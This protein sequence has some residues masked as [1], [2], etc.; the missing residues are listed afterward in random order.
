MANVNGIYVPFIVDV[1]GGMKYAEEQVEEQ[2]KRLMDKMS[3]HA[4]SLRF[5]IDRDGKGKAVLKSVNQLLTDSTLSAENLDNALKSI[6]KRITDARA[7][8]GFDM[9][10]GLTET[11]K[12]LLQVFTVVSAKYEGVGLLLDKLMSDTKAWAKENVESAK[13]V[14][15]YWDKIDAVIATTGNSF[16]EA[17]ARMKAAMTKL[18]V[19][20]A[21]L[22]DGS[23]NVE[24]TNLVSIVKQA[25][26]AIFEYQ[27]QLG[28]VTNTSRENIQVLQEQEQTMSV[29]NRQM[30]EWRKILENSEVG[31]E[32]FT[33][34][35]RQMGVLADAIAKANYQFQ[36]LSSNKDSI[37][38]VSARMAELNRQW[39]EA[40]ASKKFGANG[41]MTA[42]AKQMVEQYKDLS[43]FSEKYGQ[44]LEHFIAKR[45]E[46]MEHAD[47]LRNIGASM[48]ALNQSLAAWTQELNNAPI[49][50]PEWVNA[51]QHVQSL[52]NKIR[53][54]NDKL[55]E[56]ALQNG[57]IEQ[58]NARLQSLTNQWNSLGNRFSA[59]GQMTMEAKKIYNEYVKV[60][61]QLQKEGR[62][63]SD[64]LSKQEALTQKLLEDGRIRKR[65]Q[66]ILTSEANTIDRIRQKIQLLTDQLGKV[67]IGSDRFKAISR[68]IAGLNEQ[69]EKAQG[70]TAAVNAELGRSNSLLG[71]LV[72]KTLYLFSLRT[73]STF[74]RN[75]RQVT[76]EFEMQRVALAGIIQDT[77]KAESLFKQIKAAAIK[78]PFEIKDLVRFTKQLSAYRI[79]TDQLFDVTMKL[80]DVSAGLGVDMNRLVLAY[81]QVRAASVLRGQE[82]RQFTEAGIP[83]VE[84]LAKKFTE[85]NGRMVSTAE[86]FELISKRAV[87]FSMIKEIFDDMTESGGMFYKMQEKQSETLLGQWQ[88]LKDAASIMYDEMGNMSNVHNIMEQMMATTMRLMQNW[89]LLVGV[90]KAVGIEFLTIKAVSQFLP[91]LARNTML[92]K[93]AQD[94]FNRSLAAE[95]MAAKTS[96]AA[97]KRQSARLLEISVH[98]E[99][100]ASTTNILSQAWH[101]LAAS[102]KSGSWISIA[103]S[104]LVALIGYLVAARKESQRLGKELAQNISKGDLQVAQLTRNFKR[105]ADAAVNAAD[106]SSEQR[107]ALKE[108]QRTY[109]DIIPSQDMEIEKLR[110]LKGDYDA[111]TDA[112]RQ[113]IE[114]QIHEQ[115]VNQISDT[116]GT[117]IGK[118]RKGLE[119]YLKGE[120]YSVEEA[121]RIISGINDAIKKG[122]LKTE[123]D[124]RE[125]ARVI[126]DIIMSQT[127]F[128]PYSGFGSSVYFAK[129]FGGTSTYYEKILEY[130]VQFN[131]D[132]EEEEQ[133]FAGLSNAMGV[134]ADVLKEIRA[135]LKKTPEGFTKEQ[136]GTFEFNQAKWKQAIQLYKEKLTDAFKGVDIS[137]AFKT[138]DLIDFNEIF[139]HITQA[140]GT[141]ELKSFAEAIQKDYMNIAPQEATTRLVTE[142][143]TR[144]ADSVGIAMTKVQGY[145]KKDGTN[146]TDYAKSVQEFVEKQRTRIQ[147]LVFEQENYH[148]GVSNFIRPTDQE[149]KNE[150]D[151]L[152]FLEKLLDF[153]KQFLKQKPT[154]AG[155]DPWIILYKNRMKFMQDFQ[156]G[157]SDMNDFLSESKALNR[158]QEIMKGRGLSL[159][160]KTEDLLGSPEEL[161]DW[162][163]TAIEDTVA[164]IEELGGKE[165]A[166]LGITEILAKD[167][168]GRK[169]Q[170]Y[171]ELLA[172]LWKGLTDFDTNEIKK[173]FD[174]KFKRLSED[175][176]RSETVRNF[177]QNILD[178]TGDEGLAANLSVSVYGGIGE[179]FKDRMQE[180]LNKALS[181]VD[182]DKVTEGLR[183]AIAK[184]DYD[185]ILKNLDK[186]PEKWQDV[187]KQMAA[188]SQ[189]FNADRAA[190]LLKYLQEAKTFA[191]KRIEIERKS[192]QRIAEIN[193]MSVDK[194]TKTELLKQNE[195]KTAEE[196]DKLQYEAF[197]ETPIY[198]ELF[199]N[200][201]AAS[202]S[203]L[204]NM[205]DKLVKMKSE[206][207]SLT[208]TE[209]KELQSRIAELDKQLAKRNPFKMLV[210]SMKSYRALNRQVTRQQADINSQNAS[211]KVELMKENLAEAIKEYNV[212][213]A[214][215]TASAEQLAQAKARVKMLK[216]ATDNAI[217]NEKAA[218][219][220]AEAYHT[221]AEQ[222]KMAS[223]AIEEWASLINDVGNSVKELYSSF[224]SEENGAFFSQQFDSIS[225]AFSGTASLASGIAGAIA[226]PADISSYVRAI[227]GAIDIVIGINDYF[228][229]NKI[230]KAEDNIKTQQELLEELAYAYGRLEKAEEDAFGSEYIENY[231]QRLANLAAQVKAYSAQAEAEKSKGKKADKDKTKEFENAARDAADALEEMQ[232]EVS[233]KFLGTDL[234]S[235]AR[236]FADAWIDAYKEFGSTTGAMQEK[237]QDMIQNMIVES[238]AARVI[239]AHLKEVFDEVDRLAED[240][241]FSPMD[242]ARIAQKASE[243]TAAINV[244][245]TNLMSVLGTAGIN[246][247][248]LGSGL[249]GISKDI[250]GAS[251]ESILGLAAG[252]NTQNFY[253]SHIDQNVAAILAVLGGESPVSTEV[254]VMSYTNTELFKE[255]MSNIDS[256]LA[257]LLSAVRSVITTKDSNTNTHCIAIK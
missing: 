235:A 36:I 103:I 109:G 144:F 164:K 21:R 152:S 23:M 256:N 10:K 2:I 157:V 65:N 222:I 238:L 79:E 99:K 106:G 39:S 150:K 27:V 219:N 185:A 92:A 121:N 16:R 124:W 257:F 252:V 215:G 7:A 112:I 96:S 57:S 75:I 88:K 172:E 176:K 175:L 98:L 193:A 72:R 48:T 59:S 241:Q 196:I 105:L 212:L 113:K 61:K 188:D 177:Y 51:A 128:V 195:R 137:A 145:L 214:S 203:M 198:V 122:L 239:E 138:S 169:I 171:Q 37:K 182:A 18:E 53:E 162:Y 11:E 101:R 30:S 166:G 189:K 28:N 255:Q 14:T 64:I 31:G 42:W 231:Q 56:M 12:E 178:I 139:K 200:L 67:K 38:Q 125:T 174:D 15:E 1:E 243:A 4:L 90:L 247:R 223:E 142:A 60:T 66:L 159:G 205:R 69:L 225:K 29:L 62:A 43:V 158:E 156:K 49:D 210:D 119:N 100:A 135:E 146:M 251:E 170:K 127:G 46:L 248:S 208:P 68:E 229:G 17:T 213:K 240:G 76:S 40:S 245:M 233:E 84:L 104:A 114:M 82:L 95:A 230:K 44:S 117:K 74:V 153:V 140:E 50:S 83:L 194:E 71:N 126:E 70:K 54:A 115:N 201:D 199:S 80:A 190:D 55:H 179:D 52:S 216:G 89:R 191:E 163:N 206:W 250:A 34:A 147:E 165:F 58:L 134:Y 32:E 226:D 86:V 209:L 24:F 93:K 148:E 94:A 73:L 168:T 224:A 253:I 91:S 111:L 41:E 129:T 154:G 133:R 202:S 192:Q 232:S 8:G 237:F 35:A 184:Q 47:A 143:A 107:E 19:T 141:K 77:A 123:Q 181:A 136:E 149:I 33:E 236:D 207:K 131:N 118:A 183:N 97:L 3:K 155:Q 20:P 246:L 87:P 160:I 132:L 234:T 186:F 9:S 242:A 220:I 151:E 197:K 167:L 204:Q 161:R 218:Q 228:T 173:A 6:T 26:K 249:T 120:G 102:L 254:G 227:K 25:Q 22:S 85:L 81:G 13:E 211:D 180:Q 110:A 221:T 78:S 108:L 187:I 244:G 45:R 130:T 63:M 116:Y 5:E 217:K